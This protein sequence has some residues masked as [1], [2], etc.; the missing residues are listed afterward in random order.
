MDFD[1]E[2]LRRRYMRLL[3]LPSVCAFVDPNT[4]LVSSQLA[5]GEPEMDEDQA[6]HL[7]DCCDEWFSS[8]SKHDTIVC[9]QV[10]WATRSK[11]G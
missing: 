9:A 4:G 7:D 10:K 8:L 5:T 2:K 3:H 6:T 1:N 11:E